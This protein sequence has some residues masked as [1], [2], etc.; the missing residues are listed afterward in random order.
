MH[1]KQWLRQCLIS[2]RLCVVHFISVGLISHIYNISFAI[3]QF[4]ENCIYSLT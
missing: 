4:H 2:A 1:V 3:D